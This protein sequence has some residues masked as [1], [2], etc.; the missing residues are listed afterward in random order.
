[1]TAWFYWIRGK[2]QLA[3][4]LYE[5]GRMGDTLAMLRSAVALEKD[6]RVPSSLGAQLNFTWSRIAG[7][8][9]RLGQQQ[10]AQASFDSAVKA[11]EQFLVQLPEGSVRRAVQ[12]LPPEIWRARLE[13]WR[14][15]DEAAL[16]ISKSMI[17][18][19]R[20][21]STETETLR[22]GEIRDNLLRFALSTA[23]MAAIG[24]GRY[25]EAESLSRARLAVPPNLSGDADPEDEISRATVV[26]AHSV[27]LQGRA[28]EALAMVQSVL[29]GYRAEQQDGAGGTTF[30]RDLA[31]AYY[32]EALAQPDDAAGAARKR[33][34]LAEATRALDGMSAEARRLSDHRELA[35]WIRAAG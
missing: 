23:S 12:A 16:A 28:S 22:V 20:G 31:Y 3:T 18:R 9:M 10:A 11:H 4:A 14:G 29:D 2:G 35:G 25:E 15:N 13:L 8:E 33:A 32:V 21:I 26:L 24:L 30:Q 19:L 5:Q 34:S 1:M 6:S 27:A 7:L 17:E